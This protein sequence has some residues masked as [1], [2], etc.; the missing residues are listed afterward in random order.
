MVLLKYIFTDKLISDV[1][2]S[3]LLYLQFYMIEVRISMPI[4]ILKHSITLYIDAVSEHG[5][6]GKLCGY[7]T[8]SIDV[9]K[10]SDTLYINAESGHGIPWLC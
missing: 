8:V 5:I 7:I 6:S 3:L 10:H 4:D 9:L 1:S 2:A